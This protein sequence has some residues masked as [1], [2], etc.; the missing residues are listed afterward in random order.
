MD[1]LTKWLDEGR[2]VD[3]IY[4]DF[5]KAFDKVCHRRLGVKMEAA[6]IRGKLKAWICDWLQGRRQ[7][8]VVEEMESGWEEVLSSVPQGSVLR[9]TLFKL[10]VNDIDDGVEAFT[11]KFSDDTKMAKVVES[12]DD[13]KGLQRDIDAMM[14]WAQTWKMDFNVGKIDNTE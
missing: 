2:S 12:E 1:R 4:F 10:F 5:S 7:K 8:V 13:V 9:G 3:V 6:G 11:Q 14:E